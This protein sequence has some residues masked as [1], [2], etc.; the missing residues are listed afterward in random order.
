MVRNYP[1]NTSEMFSLTNIIFLILGLIIGISFYYLIE[2]L[3]EGRLR[4]NIARIFKNEI[5][6]LDE[7]V[8]RDL[9]SIKKVNSS[10]QP[11]NIQ[12]ERSYLGAFILSQ[13]IYGMS[14]FH[15]HVDKL[16]LFNQRTQKAMLSLYNFIWKIKNDI[17]SLRPLAEKID[18]PGQAVKDIYEIQLK[19]RETTVEIAE[20]CIQFLEDEKKNR[21]LFVFTKKRLVEART[22]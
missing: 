3:K 4:K 19:L 5:L 8:K 9:D 11:E 2:R 1:H 21:I 20:E 18:Y 22:I 14:V 13:S 16:Y 10:E 7:D 6:I 12:I 17:P 15:S